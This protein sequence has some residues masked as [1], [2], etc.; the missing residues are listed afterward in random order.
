[1]RRGHRGLQFGS[2]TR[3]PVSSGSASIAAPTSH[4][5]GGVIC[6]PS[7]Y[8]PASGIYRVIHRVHRAPHEVILIRGEQ[9]PAC[10]SC[11]LARC[12]RACHSRY[13]LCSGDSAPERSGVTQTCPTERPLLGSERRVDGEIQMLPS[14]LLERRWLTSLTEVEQQTSRFSPRHINVNSACTAANC[15]SAGGSMITSARRMQGIGYE[16][17]TP[18]HDRVQRRRRR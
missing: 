10:R 16:I 5:R 9:F 15:T 12:Y 2:S 4:E 7:R 6:D 18:T 13:G 1:M 14:F 11:M 8:A 17:R 3:Q